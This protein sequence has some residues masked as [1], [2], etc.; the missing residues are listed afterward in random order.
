MSRCRTTSGAPP[1]RGAT[2]G[3]TVPGALSAPAGVAAATVP[4][5]DVVSATQTEVGGAVAVTV[6]VRDGG[7]AVTTCRVTVGAQTDGAVPC[8]AGRNTL[9]VAEGPEGG[10]LQMVV[11]VATNQIGTGRPGRS[12]TL[13]PFAPAPTAPPPPAPVQL[14][15]GTYRLRSAGDGNVLDSTDCRTGDDIEVRMWQP[16]AAGHC[17]RFEVRSIGGGNY[18]IYETKS[19]KALDT[20]DESDYK[21]VRLEPYDGHECQKWRIERTPENAYYVRANNSGRSLMPDKCPGKDS[22]YPHAVSF[23]GGTCESWYFD[24]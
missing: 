20:C 2:T 9:R 19:G 24:D 23:S 1:A 6:D 7:A 15:D 21:H 11:A 18:T 17:Q 22:D 3:P 12:A 4:T 13:T 16:G 14:P 10:P 5:V 8:T